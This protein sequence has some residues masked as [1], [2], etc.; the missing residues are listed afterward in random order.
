MKHIT[1]SFC[2][3][4]CRC[5]CFYVSATKY[6]C[7]E[8]GIF[9]SSSLSYRL[10]PLTLPVS[11]SLSPSTLLLYIKQ[12]DKLWPEFFHMPV[13]MLMLITVLNDGTLIAIGYDKHIHTHTHTHT[14]MHT[15][16]HEYRYRQ[17]FQYFST[18]F[19][20]TV[21]LI[22]TPYSYYTFLLKTFSNV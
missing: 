16:G 1:S 12:D 4:I 14:R 3:V 18:I 8:K 19:I 15:H 13:L 2:F 9:F 11:L 17:L 20:C 22:F 7:W 21:L 5:L 10:L 6:Y